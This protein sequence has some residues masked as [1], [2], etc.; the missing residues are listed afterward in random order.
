MPST[1]QVSYAITHTIW[2]HSYQV[3]TVDSH[4]LFYV[5]NSHWTPGK[6]TL[7]FHEINEN[8]PIRAVA[9]L[10]K[11]S[12]SIDCGIGDPSNPTTIAYET[13]TNIGFMKICYM[14][15][16][17]RGHGPEMFSWKK[18]RSHGTGFANNYKMV[19]ETTQKVIAVF[20]S[21]TNPFSASK[22]GR[23]DI[24]VNYGE[25]F[26]LM[27]LITGIALHEKQRRARAAAAGAGGGGGGA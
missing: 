17:D 6:P 20:S 4:P 14:F 24:Y 9:R 5:E 13:M 26:N 10:A 16:V 22:A 23:I 3:S 12:Q 25:R 21:A 11:M 15:R 1:P 18:T 7:S 8:G 19:S 27:T 2:K